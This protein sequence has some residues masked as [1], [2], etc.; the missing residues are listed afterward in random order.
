MA[1]TITN[2]IGKAI[3]IVALIV[4]I[5]IVAGLIYADRSA[6]HPCRLLADMRDDPAIVAELRTLLTVYLHRPDVQEYLRDAPSSWS[7]NPDRGGV[8]MDDYSLFDRYEIAHHHLNISIEQIENTL[9]H[10]RSNPMIVSVA[11]SYA[12]A[13]LMFANS[14]RQ[15]DESNV[16]LTIAPRVICRAT[17]PHGEEWD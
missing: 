17:D 7:Y 3:S 11:V 2:G 5:L 6:S 14:A 13:D 8:P 15:S 9:E 1:T 16:E 10:S 12:R 4:A